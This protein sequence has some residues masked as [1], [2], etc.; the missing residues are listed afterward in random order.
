M[1]AGDPQDH[2]LFNSA[3]SGLYATDAA[4]SNS[5]TYQNIF[6][7]TITTRSTMSAMS[8]MGSS[9]GFLYDIAKCETKEECSTKYGTFGS[10]LYENTICK[11]L[12]S[13]ITSEKLYNTRLNALTNGIIELKAFSLSL[14][15]TQ[16]QQE[17]LENLLLKYRNNF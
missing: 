17:Q 10:E 12:S 11:I 15:Q 16:E 8:A 13:A 1:S 3:Y 2:S 6:D 5:C 9:L 14:I 4:F 7:N